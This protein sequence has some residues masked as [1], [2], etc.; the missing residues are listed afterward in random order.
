MNEWRKRC[1]IREQSLFVTCIGKKKQRRTGRNVVYILLYYYSCTVLRA[2]ELTP[3]DAN[4]NLNRSCLKYG[5]ECILIMC[6]R[7]EWPLLPAGYSKWKVPRETCCETQESWKLA[8]GRISEER[9]WYF[10]E[11][12]N[13]GTRM[14]WGV[15][16]VSS[17]SHNN[18]IIARDCPC[19][20][21]MTVV[22]AC[23]YVIL[24]DICHL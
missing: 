24:A 20:I 22:L 5:F 18:T 19:C 1:G 12:K 4:G 9:R 6:F 23:S 15:L 17:M 21:T 2:T 13:F 7:S 11:T 14:E 16:S 10:S 3:K 8:K